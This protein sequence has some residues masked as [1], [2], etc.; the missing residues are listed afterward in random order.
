MVKKWSRGP[1]SSTPG[2]NP[3]PGA[4]TPAAK[5]GPKAWWT[6]GSTRPSCAGIGRRPDSARMSTRAAMPMENQRLGRCIKNNNVLSSLGYF[7]GVMLMAMK[8]EK[9]GPER[10]YSRQGKKPPT[11]TYGGYPHRSQGMGNDAPSH[12][13]STTE[14]NTPTVHSPYCLPEGPNFGMESNPASPLGVPDPHM[15]SYSFRMEVPK[16]PSFSAAYG[17]YPETMVPIPPYDGEYCVAVPMYSPF[18]LQPVAHPLFTPAYPSYYDAYYPPILTTGFPEPGAE[19]MADK[20]VTK[21]TS[22]EGVGSE[23]HSLGPNSDAADEFE[24]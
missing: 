4:L 5:K 19:A 1:H 13:N 14:P 18:Y 10:K 23:D 17:P 21:N 2:P 24:E 15:P 20:G 16:S 6:H 3:A 11:E 22:F 9:K 7:S 8:D 12:Q